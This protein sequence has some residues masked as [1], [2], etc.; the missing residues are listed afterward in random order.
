MARDYTTTQRDRLV[1]TADDFGLAREVNA[2]VEIAHRDVVLTA[3]S[4]MVGEAAAANAIEL[5]RRLPSLRV[6]LH[7]ALV[8]AR[9]VLPASEIPRLVGADGRLRGDMAGLAAALAASPAARRQMRAEIEAQFSAFAATGL[10]LDHVNAHAHYH[11]NPIVG[12]MLLDVGRRFG[13]RGLRVPRE[14]S[15]PLAQ[16]EPG[17]RAL[18]PA[19]EP[20]LAAWLASHARRRRLTIPDHVFGLRWSGAMHTDRLAGILRR[21]PPGLVEIYLHP[22]TGGGFEGAAPGYRYAD[23]LA[24]LVDPACVAAVSAGRHAT[25]GYADA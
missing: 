14:P 5:A 11:L 8:D 7:V 15:R 19:V 3:A 4:L 24:A 21:L 12:A 17:G 13:M 22:A 23:E 16:I 9:P 1:I 25:G 18:A 2:A 20:L 6:G 10:P